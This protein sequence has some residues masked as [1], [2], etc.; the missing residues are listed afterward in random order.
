LII[1]LQGMK[2]QNK[3][4]DILTIGVVMNYS[5]KITTLL[6]G[7][8][9]LQPTI[10]S[11]DDVKLSFKQVILLAA[12]VA[13][14]ANPGT[15]PDI[16]PAV[17]NISA[18]D[19]F[20]IQHSAPATDD[21]DCC[22]VLERE[23]GT[24]TFPTYHTIS[25]RPSLPEYPFINSWQ[26]QRTF[27]DCQD[28]IELDPRKFLRT[29][30]GALEVLREPV[31]SADSVVPC[32][33]SAW[34]VSFENTKR[35]AFFGPKCQRKKGKDKDKPGKIRALKANYVCAGKTFG[36]GRKPCKS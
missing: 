4:L 23:S 18:G 35:C 19:E 14:N 17:E 36:G 32:G 15:A 26:M 33:G 2:K 31:C 7:L 5:S 3:L 12:I 22:M 30:Q 21:F 9:L 10:E 11:N 28:G 8:I 34:C 6:I 1:L 13:S 24:V 29:K 16:C 25:P 27:E 20:T